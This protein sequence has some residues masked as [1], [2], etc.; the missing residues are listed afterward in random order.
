MFA[1]KDPDSNLVN[2]TDSFATAKACGS[3][4]FQ[5]STRQGNSSQASKDTCTTIAS[6]I[7]P[8]SQ[9]GTSLHHQEVTL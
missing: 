1:L 6:V 3:S 9:G 4:V 8:S 5:L 2:P 7:P